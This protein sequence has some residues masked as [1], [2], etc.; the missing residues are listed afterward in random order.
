MENCKVLRRIQFDFRI[1]I[2]TRVY[3]FIWNSELFRL[4][5]RCINLTLS[6]AIFLQNSKAVMSIYQTLIKR[7]SLLNKYVHI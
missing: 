2:L 1:T 6:I 7:T 4:K 3:F 5:A